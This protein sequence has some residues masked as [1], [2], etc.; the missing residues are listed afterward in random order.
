[1]N[2]KYTAEQIMLRNEKK[3]HATKEDKDS[4]LLWNVHNSLQTTET[5]FIYIN[6]KIDFWFTNSFWITVTNVI[7]HQTCIKRN[8]Y[9]EWL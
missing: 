3:T 1:M 9:K 5:I 7:K 2:R 6:L 4:G 8:F